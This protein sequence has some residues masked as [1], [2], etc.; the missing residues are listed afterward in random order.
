M[1]KVLCLDLDGVC[2]SW[3]SAVYEY[4]KLYKNYTG[5]KNDLWERDHLKFSAGDWE[6]LT[7]IDI[8]YSSQLPSTDCV[9]FLNKVESLFSDIYYVTSRPGLVKTTTEQ[10]LRRHKFPFRENLIFESD[11]VN[12][13]RRV[14]ADYF[15]EDMPRHLSGLSK[16]TNVIMIAQPY[17]K[18]YWDVYPT[19]HSLMSTLQFMEI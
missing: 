7:N 12:T 18:E 5:T 8:F 15:I 4:L 10:Y 13:A 6:F 1:A 17:N 9:T 14:K 11:K 2:Y 3:H 16:V 19:A